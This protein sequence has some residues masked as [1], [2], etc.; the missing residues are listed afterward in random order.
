[1]SEATKQ[2]RT[3][4]L[5]PPTAVRMV[6]A[7][8]GAFS[9]DVSSKENAALVETVLKGL[10]SRAEKERGTYPLEY[11]YV[12]AAY[13]TLQSS[14]RSLD[15]V[16]KG[17]TL[18]F[19]ENEQ[20][21]EAYLNNVRDSLNFGKTLQDFLK[22]LPTMTITAAGGITFFQWL[23]QRVPVFDDPAVLALLGLGLAGIGYGINLLFVRISRRQM[24]F[25]YVRQDYDRGLYYEQY[26]NRVQLI[27][28][29]LLNDLERLHERVFGLP[30]LAEDDNPVQIVADLLKD[31]RPTHCLLIHQHMRQGVIT[32]KLWPTC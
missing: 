7:L 32:P 11:E 20:L 5:P 1:M 3:V 28:N 6:W 31:V 29:A 10:L 24:Q 27:L 17:R 4:L 15:T 21:R 16:Y 8:T 18:N 12:I 19:Y 26:V 22:S 13:A 25:N 9:D 14:L 23:G 30:Y 2:A